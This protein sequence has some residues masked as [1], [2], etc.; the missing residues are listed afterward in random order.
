M[1]A[2]LAITKTVFDVSLFDIVST[3]LEEIL[4]PEETP[5]EPSL[6]ELTAQT[7][8]WAPDAVNLR[9]P[10]ATRDLKLPSLLIL[11]VG[12][13]GPKPIQPVKINPIITANVIIPNF[14]L[15]FLIIITPAYSIS[16]K[17]FF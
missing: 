13:I 2:D 15:N 1:L 14:I 16:Q 4:V 6:E 10:P 3:P 8:S 12:V 11:N 7:T 9:V 5:P 17:C